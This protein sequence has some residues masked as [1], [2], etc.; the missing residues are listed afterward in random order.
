VP[1][2]PTVRSAG[3]AGGIRPPD[4]GNGPG[5]GGGTMPWV[6]LAGVTLLAA[7]GCAVA[8]GVRRRYVVR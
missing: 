3:V 6:Q 7:G 1:P 4:T 8:F 5:E 2:P